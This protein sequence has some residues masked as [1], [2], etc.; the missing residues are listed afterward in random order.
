MHC[1]IG[2]WQLPCLPKETDVAG[3]ECFI[4]VAPTPATRPETALPAT[5]QRGKTTVAPKA[6]CTATV[7][8]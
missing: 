5:R 8:G 7:R 3:A 2:S 1:R 4:A 6:S